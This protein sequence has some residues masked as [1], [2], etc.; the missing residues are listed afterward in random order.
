MQRW[1]SGIYSVRYEKKMYTLNKGSNPANLDACLIHDDGEDAVFCELFRKHCGIE[2]DIRYI[3]VNEFVA[4]M[5][6]IDAELR[7]LKRY[8][9]K[10]AK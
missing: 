7:A 5:Y 9:C 4:Y 1:T 3:P 10:Q 2:F 6:K 8:G